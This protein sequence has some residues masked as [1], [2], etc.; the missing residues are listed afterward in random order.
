MSSVH[1]ENILQT[2][3]E[4]S[5]E[6]VTAWGE[7]VNNVRWHPRRI[8]LGL[9]CYADNVDTVA[10]L[11]REDQK[12]LKKP[13]TISRKMQGIVEKYE[14]NH[15]EDK[16]LLPLHAAIATRSFRVGRFLLA[17]KLE[18]GNHFDPNATAA[19]EEASTPLHLLFWQLTRNAQNPDIQK[20]VLEFITDLVLAGACPHKIDDHGKSPFTG[21]LDA[22][23]RS[24]EEP[25]RLRAF[26]A[27]KAMAPGLGQRQADEGD[28]ADDVELLDI[29][30]KSRHPANSDYLTPASLRK[31]LGEA[32]HPR[33][34]DTVMQ[35]LLAQPLPPD[36]LDTLT[37]FAQV[38]APLALSCLEKKT[39][40]SGLAQ[41]PEADVP[42]VPRL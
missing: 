9:A 34:Q 8:L 40:E 7:K 11:L 4:K 31:E 19:N 33:W 13:C 25:T 30:E 2:L 29:L 22:L 38:Q 20:E 21:A 26:A 23:L 1:A 28:E 15:F 16:G 10:R 5:G 18:E 14:K 42:R 37:G 24:R 39:L 35:A 12:I 17:Q 6:D 3:L 32:G 27:L 41:A 36:I